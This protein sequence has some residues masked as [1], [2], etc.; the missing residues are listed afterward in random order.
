MYGTIQLYYC[1]AVY[2]IAVLVLVTCRVG[3]IEWINNTK[4]FKDVLLGAMTS[5]E[6]EH[7]L[8]K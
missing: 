5:V 8:G 4:P 3:L 6:R 7:Y 1:C 2:Y